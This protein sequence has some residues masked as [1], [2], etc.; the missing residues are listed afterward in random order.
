MFSKKR[1][2]DK[3]M[4]LLRIF[5]SV[6]SLYFFV[7]VICFT[8]IN[9]FPTPI[10]TLY[11]KMAGSINGGY[12]KLIRCTCSWCLGWDIHGT[13]GV[14]DIFVCPIPLPDVASIFSLL[15]LSSIWKFIS[16]LMRLSFK[17]WKIVSNM[18][19]RLNIQKG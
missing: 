9:I 18:K 16:L 12:I 6:Y 4:K 8:L 5:E 1:H 2:T 3:N 19:R 15:N 11:S 14:R 13:S 10:D 7:Y 17:E